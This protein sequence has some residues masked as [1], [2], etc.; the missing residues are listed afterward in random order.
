MSGG[1]RIAGSVWLSFPPPPA[2]GE[3]AEQ[4]SKVKLWYF[5]DVYARK[6][7]PLS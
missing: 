3:R 5:A 4:S 2:R 1:I 7:D 6:S